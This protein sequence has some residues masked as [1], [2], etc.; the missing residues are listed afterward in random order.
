MLLDEPTRGLDVVGVQTIFR[1]IAH[2][3]ES[4]KAV[5]VCTHRLDEAERLCD[6]FGLLHRGKLQHHGTLEQLREG[7]GR[8]HLVEMFDDLMNPTHAEMAPAGDAEI[9]DAVSADISNANIERPS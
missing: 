5:V 1:Y 8:E 7:S 3:R 9:G 6:R 4:G 2:L